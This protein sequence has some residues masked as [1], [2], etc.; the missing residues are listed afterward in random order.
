M[1][2]K[3]AKNSDG[4]TILSV[5]FFE[6]KNCVG[7]GYRFERRGEDIFVFGNTAVAFNAAVGYLVR[8]QSIGI[9]DSKSVSFD[10]DFRAVYFANHF[11]FVS[12]TNLYYL[13][14]LYLLNYNNIR[15]QNHLY[16]LHY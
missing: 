14:T 7:D 3:Y 4:E 1:L 9:E 5:S 11:Y 15:I 2:K 16:L 8:H 10:S 13:Q 6:D 12:Y